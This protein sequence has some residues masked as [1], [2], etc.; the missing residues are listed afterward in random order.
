VVI[1]DFTFLFIVMV[2]LLSVQTKQYTVA[3]AMFVLLLFASKNKAVLVAG[4]AG[5]GIAL[6]YF[7]GDEFA[8][9]ILIGLFI[10]LVVIARTSPPEPNMEGMY[11]PMM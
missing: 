11:P 9:F 3:V 8:P 2:L 10:I 4:V 1:V 7:L 6:V 5:A